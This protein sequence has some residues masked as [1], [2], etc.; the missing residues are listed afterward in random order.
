MRSFLRAFSSS[1]R[2]RVIPSQ[3]PTLRDF[4]R[5]NVDRSQLPARVDIGAALDLPPYLKPL[6]SPRKVAVI[7]FVLFFFFFFFLFFI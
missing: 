6:E 2:D 5:G 1:R 4:L 7:L 3:N